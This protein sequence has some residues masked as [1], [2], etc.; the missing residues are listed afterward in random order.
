MEVKGKRKCKHCEEYN[1]ISKMVKYNEKFF[2]EN[3][4][5]E[6]NTKRSRKK[7]TKERAYE[8]LDKLK[9][10]MNVFLNEISVFK[11]FDDYIC[12]EYYITNL[13]HLYYIKMNDIKNLNR[14]GLRKKID[15]EI[16]LE[17]FKNEKFKQICRNA[18]AKKEDLVGY[19][20]FNY[21]LAVA[22]SKYDKYVYQR[23]KADLNKIKN[24]EVRQ[25]QE[26]VKVF[27]IESSE[28]KNILNE[29]DILF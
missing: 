18:R 22:L 24:I 23:K 19:D 9:E 16:L 6:Y 8:I 27:K 4:F 3:C 7:L 25:K 21:D 26:Q 1:D 14:K 15:F 17:I 10:E 28:N 5:I 11:E 20:A 12:E 29:S 2:C 13:P